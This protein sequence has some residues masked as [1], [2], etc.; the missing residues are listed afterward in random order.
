[1]ETDF[2]I[3]NSIKKQIKKKLQH[4]KEWMWSQFKKTSYDKKL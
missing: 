4:A 3:S 2:N 1:M